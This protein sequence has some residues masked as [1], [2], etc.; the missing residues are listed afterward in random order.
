MPSSFEEL[1][2][3]QALISLQTGPCQVVRKQIRIAKG[4]TRESYDYAFF[5]EHRCLVF[6]DRLAHPNIIRLLG[7][8]TYSGKHNFLFPSYETDLSAFLENESR[9]SDFARDATF[10]SA[11]EGLASALCSTHKLH[12][13]KEKH[14][15]DIDAIGYHHDLRP[16]NVLI[17]QETFILADFGLS[18]FKSTDALSQTPWKL[19]GGDYSAPEC[20]DEKFAEQDVGRAFDIWAFG[21]LTIEVI[22][23]MQRGAASLKEFREQRN[24][25]GRSDRWEDS[26]FHDKDGNPKLVVDQWLDSLIQGLLHPGPVSILANLS[27]KALKSDPKNRPNIEEICADLAQISLKAHFI[28]VRDLFH[29]YIRQKAAKGTEQT[30]N[31]MKLWFESERLAAFGY[32]TGLDSAEMMTPSSSNLTNHYDKYLK[33]LKNMAVRL[34]EVESQSLT[35]KGDAAPGSENSAHKYAHSSERFE[36]DVC[37][38]VETLWNLLPMN[39]RRKAE[40]AWIRSMLDTEDVRRLNNVERAFKSGDDPTYEKG[41]AMAMMKRIGLNI[42]SNPTSM[43][44]GFIVSANDVQRRVQE[45]NFHEF[46]LFNGLRVL[47]EWMHYSSGWE[48]VRPDQRAITMSYKAQGFSEKTKPAGMRTLDCIGAFENTGDKAGYG[49]LYPIPRPDPEVDTVSSTAT[50]LQL[51][52]NKQCQPL[53]GDKIRLASALAQFLVDFHNVGWLHENFHSN[54]VLFFNIRDSGQSDNSILATQTL[55]RPYVVGLHKSRL[56]G[57][58]WD[59]VGPLSPAIARSKADFQDYQHPEYARTERYRASYDYYSLGL[60]L[61][62]LGFWKPLQV[63]ATSQRCLRMSLAEFR[64]DLIDMRVPILGVAVG[65]VY[66]DVVHFC[67][68]GSM[69][70]SADLDINVLK[71]FA[72]NVA[73]P[74]KD[75][76]ETHI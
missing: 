25:P 67:L 17:S 37:E 29:K 20:M 60:I 44:E 8:Y 55:E 24:S 68:S 13:E 22:I 32:V 75:L 54:N 74:L 40:A 57:K 21:C 59:T 51:I 45:V 18:K 27:R 10:F 49:F 1:I 61:L 73:E 4:H 35:W 34:E 72:K 43:P 46:G 5:N 66:R 15:L 70:S 12:L 16:T 71:E 65:A 6:L 30:S 39:E 26:C 41:A 52:E 63:W 69:D 56:G 58:N 36:N 19:G 50:L 23:Y 2:I 14:G 3:I 31:K 62:E 28:T 47:I 7:S 33:A 64:Q 42:K 11:L 38:L 76:A 53:L 9:F 48:K